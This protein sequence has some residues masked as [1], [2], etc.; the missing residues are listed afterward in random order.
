MAKEKNGQD[1][2]KNQKINA[3]STTPIIPEY[4]DYLN[5]LTTSL[6]FDPLACFFVP[7]LV[8]KDKI[9]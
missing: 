4:Q 7:I 2:T 3:V 1:V 8:T 5:I 6:D 9:H